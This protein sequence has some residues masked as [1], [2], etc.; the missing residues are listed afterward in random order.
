MAR[1]LDDIK[2]ELRKA[3][4]CIRESHAEVVPCKV[5]LEQDGQI[6]G[7]VDGTEII[8][9]EAE[10]KGEEYESRI[11]EMAAD[12]FSKEQAIETR[13]K[14]IVEVAA[15]LAKAGGLTIAD[16]QLAVSCG[17]RDGVYV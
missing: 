11:S 2:A 4:P 16:I 7:E 8:T 13:Q 1:T 14:R 10:L 6:V 12:V 5:P 9:T 3:N 17:I 15:K